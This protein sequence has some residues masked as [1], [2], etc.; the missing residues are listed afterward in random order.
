MRLK[1]RG[2]WEDNKW[3]LKKYIERAWNGSILQR[4][5]KNGGSVKMVVKQWVPENE[6]NFLIS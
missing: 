1:S 6:Q 2:R 4:K 3:I 5:G